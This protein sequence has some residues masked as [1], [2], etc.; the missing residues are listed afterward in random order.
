MIKVGYQESSCF[1]RPVTL[2]RDY[3]DN[4]VDEELG[5]GEYDV[6]EYDMDE[7]DDKWLTNYNSHRYLSQGSPITR[8]VFEI[9]MT[10]I[11]KEWVNLERRIPKVNAKPHGQGHARRRSSG[12]VGDDEDEDGAEDSKCVIC[13]DGECENANAIVFCDGCNL[14][15]HQECYGV[16]YIPE[17]QWHCRKCQQIPRQIAVSFYQIASFLVLC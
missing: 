9:A 14:A 11:E 16:P 17:G 2:F 8:E 15:V 13:D 1:N 5:C 3:P 7:Q 12:R 4:A 10:K 6:V